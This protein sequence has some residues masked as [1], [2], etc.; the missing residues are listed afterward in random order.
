MWSALEKFFDQPSKRRRSFVDLLANLIDPPIGLREGL[1]PLMVAAGFQA[2][3]K[4]LALREN[5]DGAWLYV[6]DVTP[7]LIERICEEP[8]KFDLESRRLTASQRRQLE[9]MVVCLAGAVDPREPDL[10]RAFYDALL[11]WKS[12]L[13]ASA[14]SD[15]HLGECASLVQP[16][17]RKRG[18]DPFDFLFADLPA[19]VGCAP[20]HEDASNCFVFAV[21][22]IEKAEKRIAEG[23]IDV[24][25]ELLNRRVAGPD[26][27][28]LK[29]AA[30]WAAALPLGDAAM[31]AL[32][33]ETR[34]IVSRAR[35]ADQDL[36]T[37]TGFVTA[38]SGILFGTGFDEWTEGSATKFRERL[39]GALERA[40]QSAFENADGSKQFDLFAR[41][42]MS[43]VVDQIADSI[44]WKKT[45]RHLEGIIKERAR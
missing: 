27:P 31:R 32:D 5:I 29:A 40:E 34:G 45:R 20:L 43:S 13:P 2:F 8:S 4:C 12:G 1:L 41:N 38:L 7:S 18:F 24:A 44:G 19:A 15:P 28:L 30:S 9:R 35:A 16:L 3:G 33:Q 37:E 26:Q 14:L 6:D 17:L 42:R 25:Y 10:V 11:A 23:A 36:R 21:S 39:D 22:D